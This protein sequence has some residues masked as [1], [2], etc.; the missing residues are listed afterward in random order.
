[1]ASVALS[2]WVRSTS[3]RDDL[4]VLAGLLSL[5]GSELGTDRSRAPTIMY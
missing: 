4:T 2:L 5:S 3:L 1:M